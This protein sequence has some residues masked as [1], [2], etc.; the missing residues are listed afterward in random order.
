MLAHKKKE[1]SLERSDKAAEE[2]AGTKKEGA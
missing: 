1:P 2:N